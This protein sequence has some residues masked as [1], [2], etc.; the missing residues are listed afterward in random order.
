MARDG[1]PALLR[2]VANW[3]SR[4]RRWRAGRT[5]IACQ[6]VTGVL[7]GTYLASTIFRAPNT[8]STFYDGWIGN[9]GYGGCAALCAWR[10][11][12]ERRQRAAWA[13]IALSLI[14]YTTGTVLWTTVTQFWTP[15]RYPTI[16]DAFFLLLGGLSTAEGGRRRAP[17]SRGMPRIERPVHGV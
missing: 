16:D 7:V 4:Q 14:F 12:S 15:D 5:L 10:A 1:G 9:L 6:I 3:V 8:T 13:A 11:I 17:R 2:V